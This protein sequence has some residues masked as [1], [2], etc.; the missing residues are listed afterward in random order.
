MSYSKYILLLLL[1]VVPATYADS[2]RCGG[3][4]VTLGDSKAK[5]IINCGE[6][7]MK[8]TIA[9]AEKTEYSE[10]ALKH[11]LLYKHGLLKDSNGAVIGS[12]T[13]VSQ[14]IDQWT[15]NLGQGT[16]LRVLYFEGGQLVAIADGDRI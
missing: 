14:S 9:V 4:L 7:F 3:K 12:K 13:S 11:P 15:Y 5:T 8:E 2:M 6:P 16:F 10:L 1:F